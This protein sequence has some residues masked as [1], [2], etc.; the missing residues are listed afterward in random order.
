MSLE[1]FFYVKEALGK[2]GK[3]IKT[4]KIRTMIPY[5]DRSIDNILLNGLDNLGKPKNDIRVIENKRR[6]RKY[7][8]DEIPQF[9]NL[10]KRD[11]TLIGIR[12]K[13]EKNWSIYPTQHK[14]HALKHKPGLMSVIHSDVNVKTFEEAI[15]I[16][17]DYLNQKDN[18]PYLTD[19]KYFFKIVYNIIFNNLRSR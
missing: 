13:T 9:Y 10:L 17:E 4:Y 8:I 7:W 16:E 14:N 5:A 3:Y 18:S 15:K 19:I 2:N 1:K 12:P 6:L 11:I